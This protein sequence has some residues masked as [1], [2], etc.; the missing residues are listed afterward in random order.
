MTLL[1]SSKDIEAITDN[2][3]SHCLCDQLAAPSDR[4]SGA[5][6]ENGKPEKHQQVAEG[7]EVY[8]YCRQQVDNSS[9]EGNAGFLFCKFLSSKPRVST[10]HCIYPAGEADYC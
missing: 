2:L 10:S 8:M 9:H 1:Q 7:G 5:L 3:V 6:A 4:F